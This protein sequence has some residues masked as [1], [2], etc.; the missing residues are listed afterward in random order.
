MKAQILNYFSLFTSL[1][2]L[3]CCALPALLVGL[4]MGMAVAG[5]V[6]NFPWLVS[7]SRYKDWVFA[8]SGLLIAFSFF[9][10]YGL[11]R[12][13]QTAARCAAGES[14][15]CEIAGRL[16]RA[17]LWASLLVWGIG[18]FMAYVFLPL[19]LYVEGL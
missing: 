9:L 5:L 8:G 13:R 10:T 1:G 7:L 11:P 19:K 14:S 4:G 6:S 2:T 15:G 18:F 16:T 17:T 3:I 12:L